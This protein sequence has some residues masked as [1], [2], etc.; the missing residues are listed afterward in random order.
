MHQ[1]SLDN[2]RSAPALGRFLGIALIGVVLDLWTKYL[3]F[4]RLPRGGSYE[5]IPGWLHFHA[6]V[7][8]GAVFGLGQGQLA[9]FIIVSVLAT[10]FLTFLFLSSGRQRFYQVLLGML[11]AGVL[12]NLYDRVVYGHV[13]D[14]IHIFPGWSNPLW[15]LLP[16]TR[17]WF[18]GWHELFPW[19][20]NIADALLCVGVG[21]M[22]VYNLLVSPEEK[23]PAPAADDAPSH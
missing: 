3:A 10:A 12:G 9:L 18:P 1:L 2:L 6:V 4:D 8:Y 5:F 22:I 21:L 7:N 16:V 15:T 23:R 19:V 14:M 11:L 13:R 17:N 20:F